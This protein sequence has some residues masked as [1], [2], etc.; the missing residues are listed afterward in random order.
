M[1]CAAS[2]S[3]L[4]DEGLTPVKV[5]VMNEENNQLDSI[6]LRTDLER[7]LDVDGEEI[8]DQDVDTV[9]GLEVQKAT[10]I[11]TLPM[12]VKLNWVYAHALRHVHSQF[13]S[14]L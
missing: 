13:V 14:R 8:S 5:L 11:V 4:E 6:T 2:L 9:C 3:W 10:E 1:D 7:A 12:H